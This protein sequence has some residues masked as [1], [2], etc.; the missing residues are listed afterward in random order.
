MHSRTESIA[1]NVRYF[2]SDV[3]TL[4]TST[5]SY[6]IMDGALSTYHLE[7][8]MFYV[9]LL[10]HLPTHYSQIPFHLHP[11]SKQMSNILRKMPHVKN[12]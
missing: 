10:T 6:H 9:Q 3:C 7:L 4:P 5:T 11:Q 12:K 2:L 1:T 8:V